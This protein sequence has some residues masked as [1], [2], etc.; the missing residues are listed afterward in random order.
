MRK[1]RANTCDTR[2]IASVINS[3]C[4]HINPGYFQVQTEG[5]MNYL[6]FTEDNYVWT[7]NYDYVNLCPS[8]W[9]KVLSVNCLVFLASIPN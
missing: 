8:G 1:E 6:N 5:T 9:R 7:T 3:F 2:K 4:A